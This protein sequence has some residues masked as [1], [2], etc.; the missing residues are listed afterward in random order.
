VYTIS[1]ADGKKPV[2][3]AWW[4]IWERHCGLVAQTRCPAME[5][6]VDSEGVEKD[7]APG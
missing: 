2:L 3:R 6:S 1:I 7:G 4:R 5:S